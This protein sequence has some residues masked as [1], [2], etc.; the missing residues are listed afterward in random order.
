MRPAWSGHV[1]VFANE[2]PHGRS[3]LMRLR[4]VSGRCVSARQ[5]LVTFA[6]P[7]VSEKYDSAT[8]R[9]PQDRIR[10]ISRRLPGI[11]PVSACSFAGDSSGKTVQRHQ[12]GILPEESRPS[13]SRGFLTGRMF[14]I[15]NRFDLLRSGGST[16]R[17]LPYS[18]VPRTKQHGTGRESQTKGNS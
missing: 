8:G 12:P 1:E 7:G 6:A 3:S 9:L 10:L 18:S 11:I 5:R 15:K 14:A 16:R 2:V 17:F 13:R 4:T